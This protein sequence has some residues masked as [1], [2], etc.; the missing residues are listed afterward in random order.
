MAVIITNMNMPESCYECRFSEPAY[1][2]NRCDNMIGHTYGE[3]LTDRVKNCPL[4][5]VDEM[6]EELKRYETLMFHED[7][8]SMGAFIHAQKVKEIVGRYCDKE[9]NN[10]A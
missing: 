2:G 10:E 6:M 8:S 3:I 7:G 9:Q 4:K 1:S 5:S